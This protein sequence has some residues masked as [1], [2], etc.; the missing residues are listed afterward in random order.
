MSIRIKL[1]NILDRENTMITNEYFVNKHE[2]TL[3]NQRLKVIRP[4]D[5]YSSYIGLIDID[6]NYLYLHNFIIDKFK[7]LLIIKK[8]NIELIIKEYEII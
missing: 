5:R 6:N 7:D 3:I 1:K 8:H 2:I 4:I